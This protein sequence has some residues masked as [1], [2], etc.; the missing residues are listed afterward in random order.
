MWVG[1]AD[2]CGNDG[3]VAED[4]SSPVLASIPHAPAAKRSFVPTLAAFFPPALAVATFL[5]AP[6]FGDVVRAG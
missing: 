2:T 3:P 4:T 1:S 6:S 5:S